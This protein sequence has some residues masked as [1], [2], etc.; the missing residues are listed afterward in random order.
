MRPLLMETLHWRVP[1]T[2]TAGGSSIQHCWES[3]CQVILS[4]GMLC[5]NCCHGRCSFAFACT[6]VLLQCQQYVPEPEERPDRLTYKL[7]MVLTCCRLGEVCADTAYAPDRL[8]GA[9]LKQ[10]RQG[11][12]PGAPHGLP[13]PRAH[14]QMQVCG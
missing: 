1:C 10:P 6:S 12:Q 5:F 4:S 11:P 8:Q 3:G 2:A 9:A 14:H 7:T 13:F